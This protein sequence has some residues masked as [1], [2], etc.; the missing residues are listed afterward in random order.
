[1]C[2]ETGKRSSNSCSR[3][4][5]R[6]CVQGR[7]PG[8]AGGSLIHLGSKPHVPVPPCA[9]GR[10][11]THHERLY[12]FGLQP[13][14]SGCPRPSARPGVLGLSVRGLQGRS[15]VRGAAL[16]A[17]PHVEGTLRVGDEQRTSVSVEAIWGRRPHGPVIHA[18]LDPTASARRYAHNITLKSH[19]APCVC[20]SYL[21][22]D[23]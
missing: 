19:H 17:Q 22:V 8:H 13:G 11:G 16:C 6:V 20:I 23:L 5:P 7:E 3:R 10:R 14:H 15:R 4:R 9:G 18:E 12:R 1:M 2:L 21:H